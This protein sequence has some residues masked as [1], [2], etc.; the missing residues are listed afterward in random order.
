MLQ[1]SEWN[2]KIFLSGD[3]EYLCKMYGLS[4]ASG[5]TKDLNLIPANHQVILYTGKNSRFPTY[6]YTSQ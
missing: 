3:Y 5:K 1:H 6:F 4:G 2:I